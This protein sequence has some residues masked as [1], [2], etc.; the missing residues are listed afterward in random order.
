MR[1]VFR[2]AAV[3]LST[4]AAAM[5]L[6]LF[7]CSGGAGDIDIDETHAGADEIYFVE[8]PG[9]YDGRFELHIGMPESA[10]DVE[11]RYTTDSRAPTA[12]SKLYDPE[13]G[14]DI[15]YRGT[16]SGTD[17]ASVNIIRC[18][19]FRDGEQV[20]ESITGTFIVTDSPDVRYS[21]MIVSIVAEPD[22][23]Y[24]YERGIL[25]EGKIRDDFLKER[26]AEWKN[27]SLQNAN[28]F[29][30]GREWERPIHAEFYT[31]DGQLLLEQNLGV[32]V[33]GGWNRNNAHKS[34]RLFARYDYDDTN[35]MTFD[36]YP[37]LESL[38]DVPVGSYKTLI[39]RTGSNNMW[40]ST[41]STPFLMSFGRDLGL[42]TME[43]RPVCVYLNGKYYGF[44]ALLEDYGPE[45]FE[46]NYNIPA[47]E[48]TC[49]DGAGKIDQS[50]PNDWEL[51]SGPES[52][53]VEFRRMLDFISS[54]D[55]TNAANYLKACEM[56]DIE[57]FV[58]YMCFEAYI[59]N[60]D[61]PQNNVRVWRR[62]TDGYQPG[63]VGY[64]LDGRWRFLLKDLDM[65]AGF[66]GGS[67]T[68][69]F[70]RVDSDDNILRLNAMFK[71]LFKNADFSNRVYRVFCDLMSR[72]L[73]AENAA[74]RLGEIEASALFEMNYYAPSWNASGGSR[75]KWH[76]YLARPV[77][78]FRERAEEVRK[79]IRKRYDSSFGELEVSVEG[80]GTLTVSALDIDSTNGGTL[81]YLVGLSIP[82]SASPERGWRLKEIQIDGKTLTGG[83]FVFN[84]EKKT[85]RAVF[86]P[87]P[88][89]TEPAYPQL[90][91]TEVKYEH[92]RSDDQADLVEILNTGEKPL[93]LKG[94][95]LVRERTG[96]NGDIVRDKWD[97][98][99]RTIAA[100]EY[101]V[102]SCD[103]SGTK[104][105][106]EEMHA[107]FGLKSGD[108]LAICDRLGQTVNEVGLPI[109]SN[110]SVYALDID[111]GEWYYEPRST[112]GGENVRADGYRLSDVIDERCRGTY[113]INGKIYDDFAEGS[114]VSE[115]SLIGLVGDS[116]FK[117]YKTRLSKFLD[118]DGNYS[119]DEALSLLGYERFYISALD[120]YVVF[121]MK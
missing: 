12:G 106:R 48:I 98:P 44:M 53:L 107:S 74:D 47:D 104:R 33:S 5:A 34:L 96:E 118:D 4:L 58:R 15:S 49:I 2:N 46:T 68:D 20:G 82:V 114:L 11:I 65:A 3:V 113:I 19:A 111:T 63:A 78:F 80:E 93:Y 115:R 99:A 13:K 56:I 72:T 7:S 75:E 41:I 28:F 31:K 61:W 92:S 18:A 76:E 14:I 90:I 23:L 71:S 16:T 79:D 52:E 22:D 30:R 40:N 25:V 108:R 17:P 66:G 116:R 42:D 43:Y 95:T 50:A 39:L 70:E 60:T 32:R 64:G 35:V 38:S 103:K 119:L 37:G 59:C 88:D 110:Y 57:S 117:R 69:V 73:K 85:L 51:D 6:A 112:F 21:T 83:S 120:S 29:Q 109:C 84:S 77:L 81:E 55:M 102:I 27:E 45:Y 91:I 105:L 62:F 101:A 67:G 10:E 26:P 86:E 36:A 89:F 8:S 121:K 97:F 24:G 87:D 54:S 100:G 1:R 9:I 94:Y